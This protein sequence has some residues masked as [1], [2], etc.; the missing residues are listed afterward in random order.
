MRLATLPFTALA[1]AACLAA[2]LPVRAQTPP[3]LS[4]EATRTACIAAVQATLP[5]GSTADQA[6]GVLARQTRDAGPTACRGPDL[7]P[8]SPPRILDAV[9]EGVTRGRTDNDC[10]ADAAQP[11]C[12]GLAA[13]AARLTTARVLLGPDG[14]AKT[15]AQRSALADYTAAV[16]WDHAY[17]GFGQS[18]AGVSLLKL[19]LKAGPG[20]AAAATV[21]AATV[22]GDFRTTFR[23]TPEGAAPCDAACAA[24]TARVVALFPLLHGLD[25]AWQ[26]PAG[27]GMAA[28]ADH[29]QV[30]RDRWDAYHFGGGD[31]RVQLPWELAV[32]GLIFQ[33]T[34][35]RLQDG[36]RE[37][38]PRPPRWALTVA[39]PTVGLS[40]KDTRGAD[41]NLVGVVEA[42]GFSKWT[43]GE[44]NRRSRE[45]GVS[46]VAAYQPRD[47]GH[48]WGYGV[49]A[50]LPWR[51]INLAWTRAR[52]DNG[53]DFDQLL[54]SVDVSKY[55]G[56]GAGN[57]AKLFKLQDPAK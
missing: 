13:A 44:D 56:G 50:R 2:P 51:G 49:L 15:A 36:S 55:I 34:R 47:N 27:E 11:A 38:F 25:V 24:A 42:L 16:H 19:A 41:S 4:F 1:L 48:D 43:Y 22:A 32:N 18:A 29:L 10:A 28:Y 14:P 53:K 12:E 31:A 40:L 17:L 5:A 3:P 33:R 30:T 54:V 26:G 39:H 7:E 21:D 46:A 45:W 52:L 57:L 35:P 9:Q 8:Y 23:A 20:A 37:P 6:I